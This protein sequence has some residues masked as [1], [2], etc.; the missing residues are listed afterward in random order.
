MVVTIPFQSTHLKNIRVVSNDRT[1]IYDLGYDDITPQR[2][3]ELLDNIEAASPQDSL[4][5]IHTYRAN[6]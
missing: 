5:Y 2:F 3:N 6:D 4:Q 1:V